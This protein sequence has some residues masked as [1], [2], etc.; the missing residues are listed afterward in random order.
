MKI[1]FLGTPDFA[2]PS[3]RVLVE[4]GYEVVGVVTAPDKPVGRG[5]QMRMTPIKEY[6]LS[7]QLH[8]MQPEKLRNPEFQEALRS[9]EA[10]LFIVV[11]F[12]M[13][14]ESVWGMPP[15][16]TFNLHASLLPDYRGAAPL[17]WAI[18]N[19]ET[20]TGATTFFLEHEIDTGGILLQREMDIPDHWTA[21]DLH[22]A[23]ME[24]GG[25]LVLETVRKIEGGNAHPSPQ[26]PTKALHQAPKIFREDC[27]IH[28]NR[29]IQQIR[30]HIRGM[31]P[32][33]TA[34]T[35]LEGMNLKIF[36]AECV[37]ESHNETPGTLRVVGKN[38][39]QIAGQEGWLS[40]RSL[41][42]EGKKR[43]DAASFLN[44]LKQL[45]NAV[46]TEPQNH[47]Q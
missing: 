37:A 42:L 6:A 44:G 27:Q 3:L 2:I 39:L 43:M 46:A 5:Q 10:D 31:A 7:K 8:I 9:L 4:N 18:I 17:N 12:R 26:D 45:P 34:W 21:G 40:I 36:A 41:Q 15:K 28:W 16:G 11:A 38:D 32:Y 24:M 35:T 23:M 13:L 47:V 1:V 14:P 33:P 22:D 30:N 19:G 25:E 29:P 20:K